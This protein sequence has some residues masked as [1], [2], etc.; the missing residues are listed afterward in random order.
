[1]R[2]TQRQRERDREAETQAEGEAGSMQGAWHGT[3]SQVSR[4]TSWAEGGA[5]PLSHRGCPTFRGYFEGVVST[6]HFFPPPTLTPQATLLWLVQLSKLRLLLRSLC[7]SIWWTFLYPFFPLTFLLSHICL[8]VLFQSSSSFYST[9]L[10]MASFK[11][12]CSRLSFFLN[13]IY[14]VF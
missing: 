13:S 12:P 6:F 3:G 4:I 9:G 5:K 7:Y 11:N 1:M 8:V 14:I 10:L 2:D